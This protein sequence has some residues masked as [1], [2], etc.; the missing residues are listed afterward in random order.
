MG[1]RRLQVERQRSPCRLLQHRG[2]GQRLQIT[3]YH[4]KSCR[5][6]GRR[7][8]GVCLQ[9]LLG[10]VGGMLRPFAQAPSCQVSVEPRSCQVVALDKRPAEGMALECAPEAILRWLQV[11]LLQELDR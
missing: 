10:K 7:A 3:G 2:S 5:H 1:K 4:Q 11:P 9:L 6:R 8:G